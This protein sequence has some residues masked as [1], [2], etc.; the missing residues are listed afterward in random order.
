MTLVCSACGLHVDPGEVCSCG[1]ISSPGHAADLA[2]QLDAEA[3]ARDLE[4]GARETELREEVRK[5]HRRDD[6]ETSIAAAWSVVEELRPRQSAVLEVMKRWGP[7]GLIDEQ[8]CSAYQTQATM[9]QYAL[10]RQTDS[11]IRSRR[12]ELVELGLVVATDERRLTAAGRKSIVWK[13][14]HYETENA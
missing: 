11:G 6:P 5:L 8:L 12:N 1:E 7:H 2:E 3:M 13:L 14:T 4:E 9:P 10:P